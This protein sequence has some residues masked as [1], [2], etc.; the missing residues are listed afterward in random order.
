MSTIGVGKAFRDQERAARSARERRDGLSRATG[1]AEL[2]VVAGSEPCATCGE[3]TPSQDLMFADAGAVCLT[4]FGEAESAALGPML[5]PWRDLVRQGAASVFLS[6]LALWLG[7]V[8]LTASASTFGGK[9]AVGWF[10]T[11]AGLGCLATLVALLSLRTTRD[12]LRRPDDGHA[13]ARRLR[14]AVS[15][16]SAGLAGAAVL[17]FA[18]LSVWPF[19]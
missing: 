19:F 18:V 17:A 6:T 5:T 4:C 8:A 9:G 16:P 10:V 1:D 11:L 14:L 15:V 3:D 12:N 7:G 2:P 13:V